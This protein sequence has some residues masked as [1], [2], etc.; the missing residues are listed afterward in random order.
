[1]KRSMSTQRDAYPHSLS[2]HPETFTSVPST[3][4]VVFESKMHEAGL[5]MKSG[6]PVRPHT[7]VPLRSPLG[8]RGLECGVD[9]RDV[10]PLSTSW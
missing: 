1:M 10:R 7:E 5:P 8:Q 2:Y 6:R 3:T 9:L 4:I